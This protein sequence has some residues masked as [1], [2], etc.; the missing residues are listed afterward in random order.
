MKPGITPPSIVRVHN[1]ELDSLAAKI[2]S[3]LGAGVQATRT[4]LERYKEAG[5]AL[6]QAKARCRHGEW[7]PWL[8]AHA[9]DRFES[10]RAMRIASNWAKC[11]TLPHL[12]EALKM[13]SAGEED[14]PITQPRPTGAVQCAGVVPA[15]EDDSERQPGDDSEQIAAD[16]AADKRAVRENG[17]AVFDWRTVEKCF[18]TIVRQVDRLAALNENGTPNLT[19][20]ELDVA[21]SD[22]RA[23]LRFWYKEITRLEPPRLT[24]GSVR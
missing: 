8:A 17:K 20:E 23:K 19:R 3:A 16:R 5:E 1:A 7:L 21:L 18:G 12:S 11:A 22:F 13:L 10:A 14:G 24:Q 2:T 4:A 15:R 6:L 9:I